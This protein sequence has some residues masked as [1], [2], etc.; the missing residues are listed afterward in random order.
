MGTFLHKQGYFGPAGVDIL[1]MKNGDYQIV[2]LNVRTSGSLSLP[3]LRTHFTSRGFYSA[4]SI[5]VTVEKSRDA[6]CEQWQAELK[7]GQLCILAW[8][9]DQRAGKSYGDVVVGAK[10]ED[11]LAKML[12]KVRKVSEQVTF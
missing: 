1:E 8:Y 4:S 10:D 12:E 5:S 6:F 3:L 7:A 11:D 9:E 2:D